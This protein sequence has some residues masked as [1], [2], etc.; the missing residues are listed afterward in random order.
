MMFELIIDNREH[1]LIM[2]IPKLIETYKLPIETKIQPLEIGDIE[3][4]RE[5]ELYYI[6]ERKS[7]NDLASSITDGRYKEQSMRLQQACKLPS[8]R[9]CYIIEGDLYAYGAVPKWSRSRSGR[10]GRSN[11]N[12]RSSVSRTTL[13]GCI[14]SLTHGKQ[15]NVIRTI[16]IQETAEF[17]VRFTDK[18]RRYD[19]EHGLPIPLNLLDR[20]TLTTTTRQQDST[21]EPQLDVEPQSIKH[22]YTYTEV[23]HK[24]KHKNITPANIGV[25]CLSQ[26]PFISQTTAQVLIEHYGTFYKCIQSIH[27]NPDELRNI[28]VNGRRLSSRVIQNLIDYLSQENPSDSSTLTQN[29]VITVDT[30][31]TTETTE[32]S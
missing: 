2:L 13:Y 9:K 5:N 22:S 26:I 21:V 23:I 28:K 1:E 31:E 16:H 4:R 8:H 27:E 25:I 11:K 10:G 20:T 29:N 32:T 17:I 30:T 3:M 24:T 12:G 19:D 7:L 6:F 15:M 18:V 14:G